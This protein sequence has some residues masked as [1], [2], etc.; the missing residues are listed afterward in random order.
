MSRREG[1]SAIVLA[2]GRGTRLRPLTFAV[3]KPLLPV[4]ERPILEIVLR[5]LKRNG[6]RQVFLAIGYRAALI[7]SYFNSHNRLGLA[8]QFVEEKRRMGTAG[9][10]KLAVEQFRISE[11]VVVMNGDILTRA[12]IRTMM[13]SHRRQRAMTARP[14]RCI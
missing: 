8:I 3:P 4:R 1:F 14:G 13:K 7:Q 9:P 12:N 5:H 6:C 2:G 11:P 10:I